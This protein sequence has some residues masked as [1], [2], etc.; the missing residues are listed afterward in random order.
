MTPTHTSSERPH[1]RAGLP[2]DSDEMQ[3]L[4]EAAL[5]SPH[6][7]LFGTYAHA[8]FSYASRDGASAAEYL[9]REVAGVNE[10]ARR[11]LETAGSLGLEEKLPRDAR[12]VLAVGAT[13][14]AHA[15]GP[16]WDEARRAAGVSDSELVGR[17]ELHAGN[18]PLLDEQQTATN[19]VRH[20]DVAISVG[21]TIIS[22]YPQRGEALCDA[23]AIAMSKD[24]GPHPGYG[25]V[26][27]PES[28]ARQGWVL[29]RT[30]QEHGII[31]P[32]LPGTGAG[33]GVGGGGEDD[34]R[35][36]DV[37]MPKIGQYVQIVPQHAC[38]TVAQ[39]P[40]LLVVGEDGLVDDVW[41]PCKGW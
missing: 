14:T 28:M 40:W 21:A 9:A 17:I 32:A 35:A 22:A 24:V 19:L 38:L 37:S 29:A 26:V 4:I 12:L 5:R 18:Y 11:V 13:P 27:R 23:G 16:V 6:I 15:A 41:V 39:H 31:A 30:S 2:P 1:R 33:A 10:A 7:S 3:R 25:P 34:G 8:G 36:Q 20:S